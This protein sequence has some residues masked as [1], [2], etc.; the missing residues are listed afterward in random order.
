MSFNKLSG[1]GE[2]LNPQRKFVFRWVLFIEGD[3]GGMSKSRI[4][5]PRCRSDMLKET[6]KR[7]DEGNMRAVTLVSLSVL[8]SSLPLNV[9]DNVENRM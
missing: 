7:I 3:E 5:V 2:Q 6:Y 9:N 4:H 1:S 8:R